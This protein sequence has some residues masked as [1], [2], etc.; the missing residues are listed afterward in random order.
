VRANNFIKLTA[1][2]IGD[3][4]FAVPHRLSGTVCQ[5]TC[6]RPFTSLLVFRNRLK[7]ELY[8]GTHGAIDIFSL[9]HMFKYNVNSYFTEIEMC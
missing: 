2:L 8:T 4:A 1:A 7:L 9:T 5:R 6:G 3:R